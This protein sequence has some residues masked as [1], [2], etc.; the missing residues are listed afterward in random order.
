[1]LP[2]SVGCMLFVRKEE[3]FKDVCSQVIRTFRR[4]TD[5]DLGGQGEITVSE[6]GFLVKVRAV[7]SGSIVGC[8]REHEL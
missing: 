8:M 5:S 4:R 2:S 1:M 3:Y 6:W 7:R